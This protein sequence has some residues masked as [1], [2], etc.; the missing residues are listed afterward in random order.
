MLPEL[1][2]GGIALHVPD[3][4]RVPGRDMT[5]DSSRGK[6]TGEDAVL[7]RRHKASHARSKVRFL[8]TIDR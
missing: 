3:A 7:A 2:G 4:H 6:M 1:V 8:S 5:R